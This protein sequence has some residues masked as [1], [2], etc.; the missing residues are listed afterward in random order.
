MVTA[1]VVEEDLQGN[2]VEA[3]AAAM[4]A[5]GLGQTLG[6]GMVL[7]WLGRQKRQRW[8]WWRQQGGSQLYG[9]Q[10]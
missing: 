8:K 4:T 3:A 6:L 5:D 9:R 1:A 10:A 2:N 7:L